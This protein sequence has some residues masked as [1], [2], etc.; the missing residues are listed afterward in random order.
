MK[1]WILPYIA[2]CNDLV[3]DTIKENFIYIYFR[4]PGM[5]YKQIKLN[6]KCV[7]SVEIWCEDVSE[8]KNFNR[9]I[10]HVWFSEQHAINII[11]CVKNNLNNISL[12]VCQCDAGLSR[13]SAVAYALDECIHEKVSLIKEDKRFFP[14]IHIYEL[15]K[16]K[17]NENN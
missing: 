16:K 7:N 15:I 9:N 4:S 2:V 14:N 17:W 8:E 5:T 6:D 10:N 1:F 12:I 13:S 3:L 11:Q